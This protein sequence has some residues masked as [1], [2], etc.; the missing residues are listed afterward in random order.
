[1]TTLAPPTSN[2]A[3]PP[4]AETLA[5]EA[6]K[7]NAAY[8]ILGLDNKTTLQNVWFVLHQPNPVMSR[9]KPLE[10]RPL[11]ILDGKA[12]IVF[13]DNFEMTT[14]ELLELK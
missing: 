10:K 14:E 11:G 2:T 4:D 12:K 1:M 9:Q 13:K 8:A 6:Q 7:I 3:Y 5:F